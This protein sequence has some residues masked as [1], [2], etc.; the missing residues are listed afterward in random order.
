MTLWTA[1]HSIKC[2]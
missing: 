1:M 2:C